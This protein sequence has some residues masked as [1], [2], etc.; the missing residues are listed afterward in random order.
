MFIRYERCPDASWILAHWP[1]SGEDGFLCKCM[2]C[3]VG[4][5]AATG[6]LQH[7]RHLHQGFLVIHKRC[8]EGF[9][10]GDPLK[11]SLN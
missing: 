3:G 8:R 4:I 7:A 5:H 2:R 10:A 9:P 11:A 6:S 1:E